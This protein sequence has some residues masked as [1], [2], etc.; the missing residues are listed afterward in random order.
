MWISLHFLLVLPNG[1]CLSCYK[2]TALKY[3]IQSSKDFNIQK[4]DSLRNICNQIRGVVLESRDMKE[5]SSHYHLIS[6]G[7]E[8]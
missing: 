8:K 5:T 2:M 4:F 7:S 3:D 6:S 1:F